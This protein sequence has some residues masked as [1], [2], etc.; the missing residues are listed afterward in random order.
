[1][2][3]GVFELYCPNCSRSIRTDD[4][5]LYHSKEFGYSCG[6]K[7]HEELELKYTRMI[8]GKDSPRLQNAS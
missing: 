6:K 5:E 1:M 4:K 7:C 8:L 2:K 3:W